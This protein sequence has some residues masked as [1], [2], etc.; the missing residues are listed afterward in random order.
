MSSLPTA[1]AVHDTAVALPPMPTAAPFGTPAGT[2]LHIVLAGPIAGDDVKAYLAPG[3]ADS[4]PTG[5]LGAPLMGILI[6]ELLRMGH[7]VTAITTDPTLPAHPGTVTRQGPG[8]SFVVCAARPRAW[9]NNGRKPGRVVDF[10]AS[11]RELVHQQMLAAGPDIVHA[12][13]SYEFALAALAQ[14]APHLITCHDAPGVILRYTRSPYRALR[15]LMARTVFRRGQAFTTVSDYMARELAPFLPATPQVIPNPVAPAVFALGRDRPRP[16]SRKVAMVCNG[17]SRRKNPE[18]GLRAFSLWRAAEP[19][20]E[21]HLYGAD[22]GPGELAEQWA[23]AQR[24]TAGIFFH[25]RMPHLKLVQQL[26][27]ADVLLHT[28]LEESFG[29]V[30][31]EAM[32]LGLPVVA[33]RH[34]GAVPWVM[35]ADAAGHTLC[36]QLVDVT[37]PAFI[38]AA[39][40]AAFSPGYAE[41]SA[42]GRRLAVQRFS[43]ATVAAAYA[44]LY[45]LLTE[46]PAARAAA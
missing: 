38:A 13:W 28:S 9:R 2:T 29:V 19:T 37:S 10:F 22:F 8:F 7:R 17:W 24:L 3:Q 14:P 20:A 41:S 43:S 32:A 25:G 15:Y 42:A 1:M 31:A 45:A 18:P 46:S 44:T 39:L 33:G 27:T 16:A 11:E 30:L 26:A 21:L 40:P 12:H 36:G 23:Q 35:G 6:G 5:Y 4:L 34:S